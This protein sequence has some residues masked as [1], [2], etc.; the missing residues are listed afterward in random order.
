MPITRQ[1]ETASGARW[2]VWRIQETEEELRERFH[3]LEGIL[4]STDAVDSYKVA[5]KRKQWFAS[6]LLSAALISD[7]KGLYYDQFGAPHLIE[8]DQCVSYSH[9]YDRVAMLVH[10]EHEV[11]LDIQ[12]KDEKLERIAPKF[13]NQEEKARYEASEKDLDYL[14]VLW[15]VKET[16]FKIHKHHLPFKEIRT[17]SFPLK[18]TGS[19]KVEAHR[20]DGLHEHEVDFEIHDDF[21]LARCV[22]MDE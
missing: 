1:E 8:D 16:I 20:F 9:S 3:A 19:F 18:S 17:P 5:R 21:Y 12:R 11:G 4:E 15:S 10:P 2:A 13:L 22:Y 6:R 14:Q 7:F